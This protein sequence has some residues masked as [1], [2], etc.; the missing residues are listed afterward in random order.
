[1]SEKITELVMILDRSGSMS[2]LEGDTIGGYNSLIEKQ[3][4]EEGECKVTTVLFDDQYKL[5]YD[6]ED[7][8]NIKKLTDKQYYARGCTAL[9]DAIGKTINNIDK[10]KEDG[11]QVL[12][13]II[14]DGLENASHEY[15]FNKIKKM[16]EERKDKGW[17]FTFLGANIDAVEAASNIGIDSDDAAG[18]VND[19][20]GIHINFQVMNKAVSSY[21]KCNKI[22]KDYLDEVRENKKE[23][24]Q[25]ANEQEDKNASTKTCNKDS[26][27]NHLTKNLMDAVIFEDDPEDDEAEEVIF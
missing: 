10:S 6:R 3:K 2:G 21:R 13:M 5:L 14:T 1:M 26:V 7:I 11:S 25:K 8:S 24:D 16:I 12:V 17:K 20:Q 23:K 19:K 22:D 18:Y 9:L 27:K 4:K 15:S